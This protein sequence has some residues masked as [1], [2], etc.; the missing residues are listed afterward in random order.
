MDHGKYN[1]SNIAYVRKEK[2]DFFR[3]RDKK[4]GILTVYC[5]KCYKFHMFF[6]F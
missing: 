1:E 3:G 2:G 5:D 6:G 4:F